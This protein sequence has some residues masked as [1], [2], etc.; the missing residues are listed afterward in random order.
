MSDFTFLNHEQIFGNDRLDI[1]EKYGLKCAITD[2][3]IL[4]GGYVSSDNYTNEIIIQGNRTGC[5]WIKTPAFGDKSG[6]V[7]DSGHIFR[8]DIHVRY[9]SARPV[10]PLSVI[11]S[12]S[13]NKVRNCDG[14]LEVDYG[15]YPQTVVPLNLFFELEEAYNQNKLITTGKT[16]T[17]DSVF[18]DFNS[19]GFKARTHIEYQYKEKKYIRFIGDDNCKGEILSDGHRKILIGEPYWIEVEPI[20]WLVDEKSG[21]AL[22][23]KILFAGVQFNSTH[24]LD[25]NFDKTFI[26]QFMDNYFSQDIIPSKLKTS[27]DVREKQELIA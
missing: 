14:I 27:E 19:T 18:F 13:S 7:L 1:I 17:T 26:K 15:E 9:N 23:K 4:L 10:L 16:Y 2:F 12:T 5:W 21:I 25:G 6:I 22:A 8:D 11:A 24:Y 3:S 20:T